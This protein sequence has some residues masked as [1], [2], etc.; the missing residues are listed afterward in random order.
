MSNYLHWTLEELIE[1][2]N[3]R[4]KALLYRLDSSYIIAELVC[5]YTALDLR[6]RHSLI[7]FLTATEQL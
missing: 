6:D 1:C 3:E 4:A 7:G 5:D 2:T